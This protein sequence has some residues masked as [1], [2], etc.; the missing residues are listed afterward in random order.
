M[1]R[2]QSLDEC[3]WVIDDDDLRKRSIDAA[4]PVSAWRFKVK[5]GFAA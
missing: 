1:E 4:W 3:L 5:A 2:Q